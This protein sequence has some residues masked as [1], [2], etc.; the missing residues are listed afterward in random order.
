M[1]P[2]RERIAGINRA[3]L[4]IELTAK[5]A[6]LRPACDAVAVEA[7]LRIVGIVVDTH[8]IGAGTR[9]HDRFPLVVADVLD[10]ERI[11]WRRGVDPLVAG[12]V[13]APVSSAIAVDYADCSRCN[14]GKGT[15]SEDSGKNGKWHGPLAREDAFRLAST[16]PGIEPCSFCKPVEPRP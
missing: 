11:D 9:V 12:E 3:V 8:A 10:V 14:H 15:Q 7:E 5:A 1:L 2:R 4:I 13:A 16:K 6:D